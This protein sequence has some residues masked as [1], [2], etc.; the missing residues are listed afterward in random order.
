MSDIIIL[1]HPEDWEQ[2]LDQV[3]AFA[4]TEIWPHIDPSEEPPEQGLLKK[5]KRPEYQDFGSN[6][7]TYAQLSAVNQRAYE[8]ARKFYDQDM[9]YFDKQEERLRDVRW[10]ISTHVSAQKKLLLKPTLTIREWLVKLKQNT[11]PTDNYMKR[12]VLHKYT[13]SLK[14][15]KTT[16]INQWIDQW[17]HTIELAIKYELPQM[18]MGVWLVDLAQ[19]VRPLSEAYFV[20]FT[21]RANKP[22]KSDSA[23]Y[24]K[25]AMELREA[26]SSLSKKITTTARGSAFNA[27]FAVD[28]PT[29][30]ERRSQSRKR[31]GTASIEDSI[32]TKKPKSPR[33]PACNI[34][35]HILPDY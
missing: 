26:L 5:P 25:V 15:L 30:E 22:E 6:D 28:D 12:K 1:T 18:S 16:K 34:K 24:V 33:C 29:A 13:E 8:N 7:N 9:K 23:E 2:W 10:H 3:R 4:H 20:T 27:D 17:E 21:K 31:A 14:G 32:S 19:A 11:Q 35:G